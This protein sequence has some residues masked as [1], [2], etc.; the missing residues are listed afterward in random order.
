MS[1]K[2]KIDKL[3]NLKCHCGV[4]IVGGIHSDYCP[5]HPKNM[6]DDLFEAY[7]A[8][9]EEHPDQVYRTPITIST[10]GIPFDPPDPD[11]V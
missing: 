9:I 7:A 1:Y 4:D 5:K 10:Y 8:F 11:D 2:D 3:K 6:I